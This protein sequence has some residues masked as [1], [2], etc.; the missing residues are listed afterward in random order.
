MVMN[1]NEYIKDH[2]F[3]LRRK[4]VINHRSYAHD[5]NLNVKLKRPQALMRS[6]SYVHLYFNF[7]HE[8]R[9]N[10]WLVLIKTTH[11]Y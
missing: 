5:D 8:T 11:A 9:V 3:E 10:Y 4:N 6:F 2:I 1:S 7:V